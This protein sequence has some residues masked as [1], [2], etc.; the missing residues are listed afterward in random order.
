MFVMGIMLMLVAM[1][2]KVSLAPFHM[3]GPDVYQ[4]A[5]SLI[6]SFMASV[7]K[8]AAFFAFFKVMNLA[9]CRKHQRMD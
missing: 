1:A 6:T 5:P 3:V 9:F 4:G 2:F 8:I 7:V